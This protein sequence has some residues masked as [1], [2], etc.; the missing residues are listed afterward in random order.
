MRKTELMNA[1]TSWRRSPGGAAVLAVAGYLA[2]VLAPVDRQRIERAHKI[3]NYRHS[4]ERGFGKKRNRAWGQTKQESGIDQRV[5]V[6]ED[7][8]DRTVTWH[9]FQTGHLNAAIINTQGKP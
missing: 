1:N 3:F 9:M 5:W 8:D 6:I 7:K 4:K 2:L